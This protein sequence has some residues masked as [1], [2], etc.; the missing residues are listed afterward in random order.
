[1]EMV[2]SKQLVQGSWTYI[3]FLLVSTAVPFAVTAVLLGI[4]PQPAII[5][6]MDRRPATFSETVRPSLPDYYCQIIQYPVPFA[7]QMAIAGLFIF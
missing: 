5:S 7:T 3:C 1:M 2:D 6:N 4:R